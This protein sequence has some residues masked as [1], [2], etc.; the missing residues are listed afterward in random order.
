MGL[1]FFKVV[2]P[3]IIHNDKWNIYKLRFD[4]LINFLSSS[5]IE[6]VLLLF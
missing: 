3:D 4:Y 1:S 2:L 5:I 6:N